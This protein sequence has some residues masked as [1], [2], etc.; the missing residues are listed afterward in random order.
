MEKKIFIKNNL[1][2]F[3]AV[4]PEDFYIWYGNDL[5][6]MLNIG[7]K[8]NLESVTSAISRYEKTSSEFYSELK[9][10]LTLILDKSDHFL[11]GINEDKHIYL[12]KHFIT[13]EELEVV[14]DLA[15]FYGYRYELK[16]AEIGID[17][18]QFWF[19]K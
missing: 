14:L 18:F 6:D 10:K 19:F 17:Y 11:L 12:L 5:E 2:F 4:E 1:P 13:S 8:N 7:T 15:K 3:G 16:Y 9:N